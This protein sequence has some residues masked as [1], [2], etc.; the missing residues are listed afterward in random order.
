M[1]VYREIELGRLKEDDLLTMQKEDI[2]PKFGTFWKKG[3]G[4]TVTVSEAIDKMLIESDNTAANM[5]ARI[6]PADTIDNVFDSLDIPANKKGELTT[7]TPKS[8]SSI[9]RS[10]Y[11]SSYLSE[12]SSN[13][14]LE[15]LTRT[16]FNDK[17][18]AGVGKDV[19]VSHKIGIFNSN[20]TTERAY[21]DCGIVYIPQRPHM[22]CIMTKANEQKTQEYMS[23]ISK[24]IYSYVSIVKGG[25]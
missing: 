8:Y 4:T 17:V 22:I 16:N 21:S 5:L 10:L 18:V 15:I 2:D 3:V 14:I 7:I 9:F 11:L 23:H 20:S 24:M 6:V 25:N 1:G 13:T 12:D 19:K